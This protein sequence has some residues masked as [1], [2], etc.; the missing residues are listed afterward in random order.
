VNW[1]L[2]VPQGAEYQAVQRGLVRRQ[3]SAGSSAG[4][5]PVRAIA[6]PA[7]TAVKKWLTEEF[8][9]F[10]PQLAFQSQ[11]QFLVLGLCGGLSDRTPLGTIV[12]YD[13]PILAQQLKIQSVQGITI[14]RVLCLASEKTQLAQESQADVVDMESQW[15][16]EYLRSLGRV[17][18]V[19]RVVSDDAQGDLPDLSAAFDTSGDLRP[20]ALAL[21]FIRHPIAALRLIRGALIALKQLEGWVAELDLEHLRV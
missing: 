4:E 8:Q 6:I 1:I 18:Q 17:V 12:L 7:G 3:R 11:T 13:Q 19:I 20:L 16:V 21:A 10:D 15:I 5:T 14:D 9:A 2:L